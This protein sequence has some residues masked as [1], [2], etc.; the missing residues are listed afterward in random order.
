MSKISAPP[1]SE[2]SCVDFGF[3]EIDIP[4]TPEP[5]LIIR[6]SDGLQLILSD[7]DQIDLAAEFIATVRL[8]QQC[9]QKGEAK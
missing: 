2:F 8:T 3:A 5:R 4:R 1:P 6:F 7:R 9:R